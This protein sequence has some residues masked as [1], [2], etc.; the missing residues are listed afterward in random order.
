MTLFN[1]IVTETAESFGLGNKAGALVAET[2]RLMFNPAKGGLQ[3]FFDRLDEAGLGDLT[4]SWREAK[5]APKPLDGKQLEAVFGTAAIADVGKQLGMANARIR[6]AM[7][8]V[9]PLLAR[10]FAADGALPKEMPS[11]I[12][13][14]LQ[15]EQ[16][17]VFTP[18][19]KPVNRN[20]TEPTPNIGMWTLGVAV[21]L[22]TAVFTGYQILKGN[23][24]GPAEQA[25]PSAPPM[26]STPTQPPAD[27]DAGKPVARLI[28]RNDGGRFD[29]SGEVSDNGLK[30]HITEQ[31][32]TFFGQARLNGNLTLNPQLGIP[33]WFAKLDRVLPQLNVPGIDLHLEGNS[34]SLG[35]WLSDQ[36]RDSVMNSLKTAMGPGFRYAY[37]GDEAL[38]LEK[39]ARGRTLAALAALP[40]GY[41]GL[42]L[43]AA[44]N[45]WAINFP[46]DH[47]ALPEGGRDIIGRAAEL[48]KAMNQPVVFQIIG[49][50][51]EKGQTGLKL[52][53]ERAN[54]VRE[55][56]LQAGVPK[57][58]L[59]ARG[60][61]GEQ[62]VA[63]NDTPYGQFKNR[64]MEFVV[65]QTCVTKSECGLPD[66]FALPTPVQPE[67][68]VE[69][70]Q[71]PVTE[72]VAPEHAPET[73]PTRSLGESLERG[74][75]SPTPSHEIRRPLDDETQKPEASSKTKPKAPK[76]AE[77][78]T[79]PDNVDDLF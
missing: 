54:A 27:A 7:A 19:G 41:Q 13:T 76:P 32:L 52:S 40:P 78:S 1:E 60:V 14:F 47:A 37:L 46:K 69:P 68:P 50:T 55:A 31:L 33:P 49:H 25:Q 62:P 29:Y 18:K 58:M 57:E 73:S 36:D 70:L 45:Q 24:P 17:R 23:E 77:R 2:V 26:A 51:D 67:L 22:V 11:A 6:T 72:P 12:Q 5:A 21:L 4:R 75:L 48:M 65:V 20:R 66:P 44:L 16:A 63:S 43:A 3:G 71:P 28:I 15:S 38:E 35:G 39:E 74:L 9:V 42:D 61:G 8:F 64:R 30:G 10:Y 59:Q 79:S 53:Q 56:L 34:V